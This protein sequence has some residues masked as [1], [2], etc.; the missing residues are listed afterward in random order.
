M[1]SYE[2][3]AIS[4]GRAAESIPLSSVAVGADPTQTLTINCMI[5]F[6]RSP[7][8]RNILIDTGFL[9]DS[10]HFQTYPIPIIDYLRPDSALARL[11][12]Q[13]QDVTDIILTH[14]HWDHADGLRLFPNARVWIQRAEYEYYTGVAW[15]AEEV[16]SGIDA[17]DIIQLV[18][19]N[20]QG[21]LS[22][23]EGDAQEI[24][25]GIRAYTG[26]KH[27]YSSQYLGIETGDET[28]VLASDNLVAY[29]AFGLRFPPSLSLDPTADPIAHH[30]MRGIA[31]SIDLI[32][33]GHDTAVFD[34]FPNPVEW[35]A[36]IR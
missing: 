18:E 14:V 13:A 22:F 28:V 6:L 8:G 19:T 9:R 21:R 30:R 17:R 7:D 10:P 5:W 36:R 15:Q 25:P 27:T 31:S 34:R 12:V 4:Y 11:G 1:P 20:T 32:I 2:I 16:P 35:V 3:Y 23:I 29:G 24:Y 33:P 26:P